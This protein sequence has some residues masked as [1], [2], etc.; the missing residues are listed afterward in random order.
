MVAVSLETI[1]PRLRATGYI[2]TSPASEDYNCIGWAAGENDRWWWPD[3]LGVDF[4]PENIPREETFDAFLAAF[5]ALGFEPCSSEA[6]E[7][8]IEKI[9]VYLN[10][11][12]LPTHM[13][14]QLTS[15]RWTSKLGKSVD[16]EHA[17]EGLDGSNLYG[18]VACL[19]KRPGQRNDAS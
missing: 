19:L 14:R 7:D 13:A 5:S 2:I 15:G 17:F 4:W 18:S 3:P 16:I 9:A 11:N 6:L 8:G 10:A 1:F 12:G